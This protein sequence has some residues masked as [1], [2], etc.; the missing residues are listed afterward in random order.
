MFIHLLWMFISSFSLMLII[1]HVSIK[2]D[3]VDKPNHRKRHCSPIPLVGGIAIYLAIL[4]FQIVND[5][6]ISYINPFIISGALLIC[7]GIMDDRFDLPVAPRLLVQCTAAIIIIADDVYLNSLGLLW[8]GDE[9]L[10]GYLAY[11]MTLL[12]VVV[13]I[14]IF[15]MA[16]GIDGLLAGL[17]AVSLG[18]LA[19]CFMLVGQQD[20]MA[21]CL[22]IIAALIP[23]LLLNVGFPFGKRLKVFM[24]DAGSTFLGFTIIWLVLIASQKKEAAIA[25][26][27]VLWLLAL[28]LMDMVSVT[29]GRLKN[30]NSPFLPDR[31]HFHHLLLDYGISAHK[32][33]LMMLVMSLVYACIGLVIEFMMLS[34]LFSLIIF[35]SFF[36]LHCSMRG[37]LMNLIKPSFTSVGHLQK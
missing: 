3:L 27:N 15:N 26:V 4:G 25:P 35:I 5:G 19:V 14:N 32:T 30:S 16:D 12:A 21:Y 37:F 1:R 6:N 22:C 24:G 28:P 18:G 9:L 10:L 36:T 23:F 20:M 33:L 2:L 8:F 13:A 7:V 29:V 17:S 11:P 34:H 31:T